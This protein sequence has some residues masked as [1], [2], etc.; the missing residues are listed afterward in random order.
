M[1]RFVGNISLTPDSS[2]LKV[3]CSVPLPSDLLWKEMCVPNC[4][5][6][7]LAKAVATCAVRAVIRYRFRVFQLCIYFYTVQSQLLGGFYSPRGTRGRV[8]CLLNARALYSHAIDS[9]IFRKKTKT[10]ESSCIFWFTQ[11]G[12]KKITEIPP[13][14]STATLKREIR[15]LKSLI[16]VWCV[17][18]LPRLYINLQLYRCGLSYL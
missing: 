12:K 5:P 4:R 3:G 2:L 13:S 9:A 11:K 15:I 7:A 14:P 10:R 6:H 16:N 18:T 8:E 1:Y 17:L